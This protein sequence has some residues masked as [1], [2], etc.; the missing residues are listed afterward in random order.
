MKKRRC[1]SCGLSINKSA[2]DDPYMCR[3]CE[4]DHG[5]EIDRYL[6]LDCPN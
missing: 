5:I 6:W 4:N 2:V 3:E 1:V